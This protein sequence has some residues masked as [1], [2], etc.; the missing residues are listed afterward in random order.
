MAEIQEIK[1]LLCSIQPCT[2]S[3]ANRRVA[4]KNGLKEKANNFSIA[5]KVLN[6]LQDN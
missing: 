2:V 4:D 5:P 1:V 3:Q 6:Q